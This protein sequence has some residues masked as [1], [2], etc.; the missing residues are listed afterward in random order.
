MSYEL[1]TSGNVVLRGLSSDGSASDLVIPDGITTIAQGAFKEANFINDVDLADIV[2]VEDKAF[3]WSS[4]KSVKF[5]DS[6]ESIGAYAFDGCS[7]LAGGIH[8][9]RSLN[10]LGAGAFFDCEK[11]TYAYVDCPDLLYLSGWAFRDCPNLEYVVLNNNLRVIGNG[12]FSDC[13]KLTDMKFPR[14]LTTIQQ[15]AFYNTGL[16]AVLL[17]SA[18]EEIEA[19]AFYLC[20]DLTNIWFSDG[21]SDTKIK[22]IGNFAFAQTGLE[23]ITIPASVTTIGEGAFEDCINLT[24]VVFKDNAQEEFL[25]NALKIFKGCK[26]LELIYF[27]GCYY[28]KDLSTGKWSYTPF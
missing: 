2:V 11:L 26:N 28:K 24:H 16:Q 6:L 4:I 8:L 10:R 18:L 5:S 1:K 12:A 9:P 17:P 19:R 20:S 22:H 3:L 25:K 27:P 15:E 7:N 14:S 23:T 21:K 13:K